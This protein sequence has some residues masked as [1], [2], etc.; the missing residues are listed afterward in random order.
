MATKI[1][2]LRKFSTGAPSTSDMEAGEIAVNTADQKIYMRDDSNNIVEVANASGSAAD[3][4]TTGDAAVE[5]ATTTGSITIDNQANDQDIIF[6]GTDNNVDITAL[7]LD[8]SDSGRAIFNKS[9]T[10]GDSITI[11]GD[12]TKSLVIGDEALSSSNNYVGMKTTAMTGT[13][14]Y[15]ILSGVQDANNPDSTFI[16]A[17]S[18]SN[19]YIRGGGNDISGQIE[20]G[21]SFAK[22]YG[23]FEVGT[24][25][26]LG[27]ASDTT[28]ERSAAGTVQIEG[29][30]I[31]TTGNAD[32]PT[33]VSSSAE[34]DHVLVND[35]GVLKKATVANL[36]VNTS[37]AADDITTGDAAVTIAT[38][39]GNITIDA[40]GSDTDI[41]FKGTDNTTDI[42]ALTLD[43]SDAGKA[44]FGGQASFGKEL[45]VDMPHGGTY[46]KPAQFLVNDM[47]NNDR[48]QFTFGKALSS[49]NLV[50]FGLSL[51][52]I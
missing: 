16:S 3:D 21:A 40:Q 7:T 46:T 18:G 38:T 4:I 27:H 1:K 22:A 12:G 15:M 35:G 29:N 14:D 6:K 17:K 39:T 36:G 43:M 34:V 19:V 11:N 33:A 5:I 47:N 10:F 50:E 23:I 52:H 45:L 24:R 25:I 42:T 30:T 2:P 44:I 37:S 13:A 9:A 48:A 31:L 8:M 51:I 41:I 32:T 49:S 26:E 28:L 20:V